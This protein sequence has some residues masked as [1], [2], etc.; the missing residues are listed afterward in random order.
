ME[1]LHI[2]I[3]FILHIDQQI[4]SVVNQYGTWTY[5]I[6]FLIIFC[7]T[8]LICF[9]FLPGDSLL[10]ATGAMS[11]SIDALDVNILF[12]LLVIASVIGNTINYSVGKMLGPKVFRSPS[13]I[14]LNKK[15]LLKA[16]SFYKQHGVKTV[17]IARFMPIIRS[18]APFIAGI[19]GMDKRQFFIYNVLGAVLWIGSLLYISYYFGTHPF[20]KQ[21]FSTIILGIIVVS[22]LPAILEVLRQI[23]L[24]PQKD[25]SG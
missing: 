7:E 14:F 25:V 10:F 12:G 11:A 16:N 15:Y 5:A 22:L 1:Y 23:Y 2:F 18:F 13:S 24:K 17:I 9:P 20:I 19:G 3:N 8:G 6:L 4:V 21:H